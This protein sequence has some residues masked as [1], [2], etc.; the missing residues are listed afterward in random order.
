MGSHESKTVHD[1]MSADPFCLRENE[2]VAEAAWEL[3]AE[4][5]GGAPVRDT[6]GKVV[7]MVSVADLLD[8]DRLAPVGQVMQQ[9]IPAVGPDTAIEEAGR[10]MVEK[11]YHR[12]PVMGAEGELVGILSTIDVIRGLLDR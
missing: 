9:E 5:V 11:G 8:A 1:V 10:I 3:K 7:G 12:L 4:L 6:S 2:K